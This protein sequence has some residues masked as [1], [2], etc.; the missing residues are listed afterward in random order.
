MGCVPA[1]PSLYTPYTPAGRRVA[2]PFSSLL[3]A[4]ASLPQVVL[5]L[6]GGGMPHAAFDLR[7]MRAVAA[8][9]RV[10]YGEAVQAVPSHSSGADAQDLYRDLAAAANCTRPRTLEVIAITLTRTPTDPNPNPLTLA[11]NPEPEP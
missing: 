10:C 1:E 7:S 6:P 3:A 8:P 2:P 5:F 4:A 9:R 11:P